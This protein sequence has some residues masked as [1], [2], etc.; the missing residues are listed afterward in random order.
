MKI[1]L[2]QNNFITGLLMKV[3]QSD[4][5][6][7]LEVGKYIFFFY[8]RKPFMNRLNSS[9]MLIGCHSFT[10]QFR[11][12]GQTSKVQNQSHCHCDFVIQPLIQVTT[13]QKKNFIQILYFHGFLFSQQYIYLS[14]KVMQ[15]VSFYL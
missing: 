3:I 7:Y 14:S 4:D 13:L 15:F 10:F 9:K 12:R 1:F 6:L 11:T 8:N 5:T 2:Y